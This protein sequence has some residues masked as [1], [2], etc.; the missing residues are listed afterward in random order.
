MKTNLTYHLKLACV[1]FPLGVALLQPAI[2]QS[3]WP[4]WH[5]PDRSAVSDESNWST[6]WPA[7]GPKELWRIQVGI[8]F[9]SCA[10]A[11]GRVYTMGNTA[12][13]GVETDS[14]W[15]LN[16]ETGDTI[17]QHQYPCRLGKY[18]GPRMT[19]TVDGD[20]VYTLS[21]EGQLFCLNAK[22]GNVRW[23]A[24][25]VKDHGVRQTKYDWGF[26]CSPLV[27]GDSL[28]LDLGKTLALNKQTGE[29]VWSSGNEEAGFSSPTTIEIGGETCINSFNAFGLVLVKARDGKELARFPWGGSKSY[30]INSASPIASGGKI[31]I[32]AGYGVGCALLK[33]DST[34]LTSLYENTDM[35][36]H[37]NSSVLYQG[38]LYG[39]DGQQGSRGRLTC[40]DFETG[41]VKWSERGLSIGALMI[42]GGKIV[43]MLDKGELL[44]TEASPGGYKELARAKVLGGR[45]W[46]YP[47]LVNGRIY[48]RSQQEGELVCLDVRK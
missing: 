40:M 27:L 4:Q 46:T 37:V 17:W 22:D 2:G 42:A 6:D 38:H 29:L 15:C 48:C 45:C 32:S 25:V 39:F 30:F 14:V 8:G 36:N 23:S 12:V 9:S 7:S 47:V 31:F 10:V 20:R 3:D 1:L 16:A 44:V 41:T 35:K 24:D 13:G 21:R 26:A 19:P 5:G 28:I 18:E 43:A 11:D 34:G 33:A